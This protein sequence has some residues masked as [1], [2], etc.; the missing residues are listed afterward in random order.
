MTYFASKLK[1][2]PIYSNFKLKLPNYHPLELDMLLSFQNEQC[3]IL[4]DEA[5]VWMESR[6][7][8]S[9]INRYV[10][11]V[12]FQSR[13]RLIDIMVTVQLNSSL[14]LRFKELCDAQIVCK[15]AR[16]GEGFYY[17]IK[18]GEKMKSFVLPM[19]E[20]Q[21]L[22]KLYDTTEIILP[23]NIEN[24]K[25]EIEEMNPEKL[26]KKVNDAIKQILSEFP[27]LTKKRITHI[28]VKDVLLQLNL[29]PSIEPYVY[30]RL[31]RTS[32]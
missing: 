13:K 15:K 25:N 7:S 26:N 2:T 22:Y 21:K 14:D 6:T 27:E 24:L 30:A 12:I 11:Y 29:S 1:N 20:A 32:L 3:L 9:D 19:T 10:S 17:Y 28:D 23:P 4:I 31:N 8:G 5:Y 16:E 18:K